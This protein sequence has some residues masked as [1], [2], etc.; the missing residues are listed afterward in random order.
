MVPPQK[1]FISPCNLQQDG[2]FAFIRPITY[3]FFGYGPL[4]SDPKHHS[5]AG[6]QYP[7]HHSAELQALL[8]LFDYL[9]R[10]PP[11]QP[12]LIYMDSS[13]TLDAVLGNS[14][15]VAHPE[16]TTK[17]RSHYSQLKQIANTK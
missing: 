17:P 11:Q 7:S 13:L 15:P 9:L 10:F 14:N 16:L 12:V 4:S 1:M 2:D 8:E 6:P 3:I 5:H